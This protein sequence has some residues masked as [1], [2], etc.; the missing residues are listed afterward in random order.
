MLGGGSAVSSA[1][2]E[3]LCG[4]ERET[5]G[6]GRRAALPGPGAGVLWR[7]RPAVSGYRGGAWWGE[8]QQGGILHTSGEMMVEVAVTTAS[9]VTPLPP[10]PAPRRWR[11]AEIT[12]EGP[13]QLAAVV[14]TAAA[15]GSWA[16]HGTGLGDVTVCHRAVA[17]AQVCSVSV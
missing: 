10:R 12:S 5:A 3:I 1:T 13:Q 6:P 15:A 4:T 14:I 16:Q 8:G 17:S 7:G 11:S 2:L 9:T